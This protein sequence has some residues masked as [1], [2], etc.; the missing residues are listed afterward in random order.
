MKAHGGEGNIARIINQLHAPADLSFIKVPPNRMRLGL[1]DGL[2]LV[3]KVN[4]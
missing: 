3:M 1:S 2:D 4:I